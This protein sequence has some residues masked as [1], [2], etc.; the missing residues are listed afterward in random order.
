MPSSGSLNRY[1]QIIAQIFQARYREGSREVA[2]ERED[3]ERAA[4][5]RWILR[6]PMKNQ[7]QIGEYLPLHFLPGTML[8]FDR[9]RHRERRADAFLALHVDPA[10]VRL[11]DGS[12]ADEADA[13][14]LDPLTAAR[15]D[16]ME[17]IEDQW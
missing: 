10:T 1:A 7:G 3:I 6:G 17:A 2:F 15:L 11:D 5:E 8:G 14:T 13:D 9:Q 12:R 4:A 16:A